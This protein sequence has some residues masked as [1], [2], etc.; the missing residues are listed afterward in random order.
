[1]RVPLLTEVTPGLYRYA[2]GLVNWYVLEDAGRVVLLDTGW[3]RSW[4]RVQAALGELGRVPGDLTAILLTHGHADHLGAAEDARRASKAPVYASRDELAR[5]TGNKAG[6]SS[7]AILPRLAPH[8]WKPKA[9]E[10]ATRAS[11]QGFMTPKWVDD[12]KGWEP[13]TTLELP[14][15]PL[16]VATPGHTEGHA[17]ILL[18]ELR[19]LIAGDALCT[20]DPLTGAAGPRLLADPLNEDT[21]MARR[22]L[23]ALERLEAEIVLPGHGD[24]WRH[25]VADAVVAAKSS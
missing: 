2:D 15:R 23:D 13:G 17:S 3:P 6:G 21:D 4:P 18:T 22:S 14:G 25:G 1:M 19:V 24:P 8:L 11:F 12:P 5:V 16:L 7:F 10:F 9:L 20:R